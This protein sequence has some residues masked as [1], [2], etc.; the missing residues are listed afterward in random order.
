MREV[1][2]ST[3]L[4]LFVDTLLSFDTKEATSVSLGDFT[5]YLGLRPVS[6]KATKKERFE[7]DGRIEFVYGPDRVSVSK[8]LPYRNKDFQKFIKSNIRII[9]QRATQHFQ[10]DTQ[11]A[12]GSDKLLCWLN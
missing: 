1:I 10:L 9:L 7:Y 4:E 5:V 8:E 11:I 6:T 3:D 2:K 12:S